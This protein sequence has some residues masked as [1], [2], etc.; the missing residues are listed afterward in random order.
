M[1]QQEATLLNTFLEL[2]PRIY[3]DCPGVTESQCFSVDVRLDFIQQALYMLC[4]AL[5]GSR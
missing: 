4:Q 1:A 2:F 3:L 5:T